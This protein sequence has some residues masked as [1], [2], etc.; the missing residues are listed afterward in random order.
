[1]IRLESSDGRRF[2]V[3]QDTAYMSTFVKNIVEDLGA[4]SEPITLPNVN[5]TILARVLEYCTHHKDDVRLNKDV[6][7]LLQDDNLVEAWDRQ[8]MDIDDPTMLQ[9]LYAADYLGIEA[10]VDLVCLFIARIIRDMPV[11]EIQQRYGVV[12][13]FTDAQRQQIKLEATRL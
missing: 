3:D 13:D 5:G 11:G 6:D 4:D 7:D 12:D 10:L 2:A 8:F 9:I 1:M